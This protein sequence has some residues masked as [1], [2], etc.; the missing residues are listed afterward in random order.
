MNT[1]YFI[2]LLVA[3]V[4]FIMAALNV[5]IVRINLVALGLFAWVL[6]PLIQH[7]RTM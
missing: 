5:A 3:A 4:C 6:V 1:L 7:I 2:L